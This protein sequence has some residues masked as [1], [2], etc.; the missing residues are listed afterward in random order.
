MTVALWEFD[1]FPASDITAYD[2]QYNLNSPT[3][4]VIN[5]DGG[6]ASPAGVEV[7]VDLDI[8]TIQAMAPAAQQVVYEA[9]ESGNDD[10]AFQKDEIDEANQI[11]SDKKA[12]I[13]SMSWGPV[14]A[15]ARRVADEVLGRLPRVRPEHHRRRWHLA[16][17][18]PDDRER[19]VGLHQPRQGAR[20]LIE[21]SLI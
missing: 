20:R 2:Q 9:P 17:I 3:P 14:R 5:V 1:A 13:V 8:E 11:V 18:R 12:S 21:R 15:G 16:R 4:T 10:N 19:L 6:Q 7:E